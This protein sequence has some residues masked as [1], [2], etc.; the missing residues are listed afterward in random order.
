[1]DYW[2]SVIF[3]VDSAA[4]NSIV[5]DKSSLVN[6]VTFEKPIEMKTA[7]KEAP[8]YSIGEGTLPIL[9]TCGKNKFIV[10]LNK[11]QVVEDYDESI[12]S[13]AGFN[14]QFGASLVLNTRCG[15]LRCNKIGMKLANIELHGKIYWLRA[16]VLDQ[17]KLDHFGMNTEILSGTRRIASNIFLRSNDK[18]DNKSNDLKISLDATVDNMTCLKVIGNRSTRRNV[19]RKLSPKQLKLLNQEGE[20]WHRRMGHVSYSVLNKLKSVTQ[21]VGDLICTKTITNCLVCGKAK[22]TKKSFN[23]DRERATRPCEIIHCDLVGPIKPVTFPKR[24]R[25]FMC[26]IDDYTRYLQVFVIRSKTKTVECMGEALRFLQA[27]FPGSGQFNIL[28]CDQGTEFVNAEMKK[29]LSQYG[30]VTE[31][32]EAGVHEHCGL[33]ERVQRTVEERSRSLL[34][35]AGFPASVWNFAVEAA[36]YIYN[37]TPHSAID[38]VTPFEMFFRKEPDLANIKIF[39][40]RIQ[41]IDTNVPKGCKFQSRSSTMFLVGFTKTGYIGFDPK[42]FGTDNICNV[43][44]DETALYKDVYPNKYSDFFIEDENNV[45]CGMTDVNIDESVLDNDDFRNDQTDYSM[46]MVEREENNVSNECVQELDEGEMKNSCFMLSAQGGVSIENSKCTAPVT[47]GEAMSKEFAALWSPAIKAELDAMENKNVWTIV[48]RVKGMKIVPLK[49]IFT[50][51]DDGTRKARLVAVGCKD[52]EVY[53]SEETASPTPG[54]TSIRWFLANAQKHNWDIVQYDVKTAFLNGELE[55]EKYTSIP[56]GLDFD[57]KKFVCKLNKAIYGLAVAPMCWYKTLEEF[58]RSIGYIRSSREP[59]IFYKNQNGSISIIVVYVDDIL[60]TGNNSTLIQELCKLLE[61]AFTVRCL[62]YP[63]TFLGIQITKTESG[64]MVLSQSKKIREML[65]ELGIETCKLV[66]TPIPPLASQKD[67]K[68]VTKIMSWSYRKII[69]KLLHFANFTR[70]DIMFAVCYLARYQ[71]SPTGVH[72]TLLNYLLK[73]LLNSVDINLGYQGNDII[74]DAFV[75]ADYGGDPCTRRSTSGYIV[76]YYGCPIAWASKLQTCIAESSGEAEN[77]A[78]CEA[79]HSIVFIAHLTEEVLGVQPCPIRVYEDNN[80]AISFNTNLT[81]KS[82]MKHVELKYHKVKEYVENKVL[83]LV[84]VDSKDQLAD[85][86][87]KGLPKVQFI[88]QRNAIMVGSMAEII[89]N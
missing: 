81:S 53:T 19:R 5:G 73:Y 33:V 34:F 32:A 23:K 76:R 31:E 87:T 14:Q 55:R 15:F 4:S 83:E 85:C 40:S 79:A 52:K 37:R 51:K 43:T 29:L 62:G 61:E 7:N 35:E 13:V 50:V 18:T 54:A 48:P 44:I 27:Q 89:L 41:N 25:Y 56:Q 88:K 71:I 30:I 22:M 16:K 1:L 9:F 86:L 11:V 74:L 75:D 84:R 68:I 38:F 26:V 60:M 3:V 39:G 45:D 8:I 59:C 10:K 67:L 77:M 78:I 80:A 36:C 70:P 17:V 72:W 49:W 24:H 21:N 57:P 58:L 2:K 6:F 66:S 47:Y 46:F 42:T 69:G 65:E 12:I 64:I 82:R 63:S 28:R 20:L